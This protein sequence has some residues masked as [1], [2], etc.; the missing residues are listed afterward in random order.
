MSKKAWI[1]LLCVVIIVLVFCGVPRVSHSATSNAGWVSSACYSHTLNDDPILFPSQPG[2]SHT[3][4]FVGALS[5]DAY[6]YPATLQAGGTCS[7]TT[8]DTA[9][10]WVPALISSVKGIVVPTAGQDRDALFYYRR[11]AASGTVQ[12]FPDGFAM[13]L[14][15]AHATSP[16]TNAAIAAGKLYW[17]CG[18]GGGTHLASPPVTCDS[19]HYLVT[20]FT[21]PQF[22]NGQRHPGNE[23][24]TMSYTRD[25]A[26]PIAL[27]RLQAFWRYSP[28][29]GTVGTVSLASGPWYTAHMDFFSTWV[30]EAEQSLITR[31]IN[32]NVDCGTDPTP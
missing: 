9:A 22:W 5:T 4:D 17:K 14:G 18:P 12:P 23:L 25:A 19:G 8:G 21:F 28:L 15:D 3:H 10:Y 2:V 1:V 26:H 20:V 27:P 24:D 29:T 32:A 16:Q 7:G 13:I 6:S 11:A 30:P 31:C